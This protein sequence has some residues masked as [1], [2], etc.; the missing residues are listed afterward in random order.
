[1][2][3]RDELLKALQKINLKHGHAKK[4]KT[5]RIYRAWVDMRRRC[6]NPKRSDYSYYGGRGIAICDRWSVF[7]NFLNDLGE[8]KQGMT[9]DRIDVNGNYS[10]ENCRWA[11]RKQQSQNTRKTRNITYNGK[12]QCVTEWEKEL[13][14]KPV[15]ITMRLKRGWSV[16]K[17]LETPRR[18]RDENGHYVLLGKSLF[19]KLG[20]VA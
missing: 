10:P 16:E 15:A 5:T 17:A 4:N 13:G 14:F 12:T 9:L 11:T 19:S 6:L 18:I 3:Q 20:L 1:M 2:S 7:V 8:P